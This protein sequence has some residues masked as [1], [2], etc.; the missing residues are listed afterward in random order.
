MHLT[1]LGNSAGGPFH[2]R[3]YTAQVLKVDNHLFLIDC[4]EGTQMQLLAYRVKSDRIRQIFISHLHGDHIFGLM[5]LITNWCLK[6]RTEKLE[7]FSPPGLEELVETTCRLCHVRIPYPIVFHVVD[8]TTSEKVFETSKVEVYSI[9]LLHR[10]PTTGWLFREK[11]LPAKMLK[12]KIVEYDIPFEL[13]PG[14]KAGGDFCLPNGRII[15]HAEL[16]TPAPLPRAYAFCSDTAPS[17]VV[18]ETVRGVNLL[19]HEATFTS[20]HLEEAEISF[21][22]TAGQAA[23]IAQKA[24]VEK[25]LIGHFSGRYP[26]AEQHLIEACAVFAQTEIS[27]EGEVVEV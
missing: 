14:I 20:D 6:R 3:H 24:G 23:A 11:P 9:P 2:G 5:G 22:S 21:H 12:D 4:G 16:T 1:V 19:Y 15:P 18:A 8:H 10:V 27:R 26:D 17:D 7:I 25:L 13:I